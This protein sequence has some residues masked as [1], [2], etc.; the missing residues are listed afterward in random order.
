MRTVGLLVVAFVV[1]CGSPATPPPAKQAPVTPAAAP[2]AD[3]TNREKIVGTWEIAKSN[4]GLVGTHMEFTRDGKLIMTAK[5]GDQTIK[6]EG[7]YTVDGDKLSIVQ[8][9]PG[10]TVRES[11][12]IREL[13][14]KTLVTVDETGQTEEFKKK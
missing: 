10:Q 14:D 12:K 11:T 7:T 4:T 1:G 6:V 8:A 9:M 5:A 13:T 2:K 3:N